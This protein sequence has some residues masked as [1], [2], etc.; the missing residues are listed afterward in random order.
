[1]DRKHSMPF[2]AEVLAD[3]SV[4]F[5]LWAPSAKSVDLCLENNRQGTYPLLP[6]QNGWFERIVPEA[7]PG[8]L[9]RFQIDQKTE[10]PDPASRFQPQDVHG[11]SAVVDPAVFQWNDENWRG[12]P[13]EEAVIYELH[14]GTFTPEGTFQGIEQKLDYL[15]DLGVTAIELMP[16]ADFP[17][18]RNWGYD[19]VLPFAPDRS[20]GRPEDLKQLVQS[21]HAKGL[22]VFLDVVYNH[23]G[24]EGNYLHV[25]APQFLTDRHH[26][27]WGEA[28]N[29]DGPDSRT[30]R[31]FFIHNALYW[32]EEY[33]FDGLRFDAVHAIV[34]DSRPDILT[35][36]AQTIRERFGTDRF[37]H[38]IVENVDNAVRYLRREPSG[39]VR[40]YNAQWNDDIHHALH[41][42]L[43]GESDGYYADYSPDPLPHLCRCLAEGFA[44]QGDYS[45]FQ[46]EKRGE[47]SLHLPPAAFVSFLQ[48][49]DQ[50][51]NRAFGERITQLASLQAVKLAMEILLLAPQVPLLFMGEEFAASAPFFFFCDFGGDLGAAVTNGRRSEFARF[52][53]FSSPELRDSI[54]DPNDE[55]TF[56]KSKLDWESLQGRVH[57]DWLNFYRELLAIR[58][59][60]IVPHLSGLAATACDISRGG[61][62]RVCVDWTFN[63]RTTLQLRANLGNEPYISSAP[64][65]GPLL[66]S[67]TPEVAAAFQQGALA[68]CSVVWSLNAAKDSPDC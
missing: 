12:R 3:G 55:N 16:V 51:G 49:H 6:L 46:G 35:E 61:K 66:Y 39:A 15:R 62:R 20:Y 58:Q 53:R 40:L 30:V 14:V 65:A 64:N 38:L 22:M 59:S 50:V 1:M 23:F 37:V 29:F 68:P 60:K 45:E 47:C 43:T 36:L 34:D 4:R 17:G 63:D 7:H 44:Y 10:V 2:G 28:I 11:P 32:L 19:G 54:P 13:W 25:Y 31:D 26:T 41:V 18:K 5:C 8:S 21:V 9:Y 48:N 57:E 42:L 56:L 33:H 24:P 27:P 52:S 67:S